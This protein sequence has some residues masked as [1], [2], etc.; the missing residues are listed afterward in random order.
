MLRQKV[1]ELEVDLAKVPTRLSVAIPQALLQCAPIVDKAI[2]DNFA[3]EASP[4]GDSWPARKEAGDG[5]PLLVEVGTE[6]S[7]SLMSAAT[8]LGGGHISRVEG[9]SLLTGVD[10]SG[11]VG[12]IPG[13]GVHNYGFAEKNIPQREFL[14]LSDVFAEEVAAMLAE[15]LVKAF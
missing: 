10:K 1:D 6:G 5:H 8:G 3:R 12:G 9:N 13:A 11:G 4:D 14:G 15:E 7:G 2:L